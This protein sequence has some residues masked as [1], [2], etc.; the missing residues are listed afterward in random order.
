MPLDLRRNRTLHNT[1]EDR[2]LHGQRKS[3]TLRFFKSKTAGWFRSRTL[4]SG[5][6]WHA[7]ELT[8]RMATCK[9]D[10]ADRVKIRQTKAT[11]RNQYKTSTHVNCTCGQTHSDVSVGQRIDCACG[12]KLR[13]T[14]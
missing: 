6:D 5:A 3:K 11:W 9:K 1:R 4:P 14:G 8:Q 13:V 10:K 12:R 2:T 7:L